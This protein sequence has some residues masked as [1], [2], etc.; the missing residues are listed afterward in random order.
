MPI[1]TF[2]G[3]LPDGGQDTLVLHT[4]TGSMGYKVVRFELFPHFP[5]TAD[6]EA[7]VKIFKVE[8]TSVPSSSGTADFNDNTLL[9]TGLY[10]G[11]SATAS[12]SLITIFDQEIFNQDIYVTHTANTGSA[13]INYY[14]ELEQVKLDLNQNTMAT[15]KDI[16]NVTAPA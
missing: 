13:A 15:L 8:Q 7:L 16:R 1:K 2:R 11:T 14:L 6:Y 9:G 4:N 3:M 12:S 10:I 5:G